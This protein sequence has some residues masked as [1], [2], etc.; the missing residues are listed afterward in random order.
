[1]KRDELER[2]LEDKK[3]ELVELVEKKNSLKDGEVYEKSR[4][5]DEL[6]VKFYAV[7]RKNGV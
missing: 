5:L 6:V 1:M 3:R 4:E 2:L 7:K